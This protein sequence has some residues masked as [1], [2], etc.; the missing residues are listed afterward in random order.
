MQRMAVGDQLAAGSSTVGSGPQV[1][2]NCAACE[3]EERLQKKEGEEEEGILPQVQK[4]PIFESNEKPPGGALQAKS[5]GTLSEASPDLESRLSA[6]QGSGQALPENTRGSMESAFGADFSSVRVHTGSEAVQM[7][8]ELGAQAFTHGSDVYFG[9]GKY[10]PGSTEGNRLLGHELT[11]VVQQGGTVNNSR[12]QPKFKTLRKSPGIQRWAVNNCTT[13]QEEELNDAVSRAYND[14]TIVLP[15][16][17]ERP[18]PDYVKNALWLAFREDSDSTADLVKDNIQRLKNQITGMRLACVDR[19][20][21]SV[22]GDHVA[23]VRAGLVSICRPTF[24]GDDVSIN[25]RSGNIIHEGAHQYL[26]MFDRGYFVINTCN[27]STHPAGNFD[28]GDQDSGTAGDNPSYRLENA[29]SYSC[30]VHYLRYTPRANLDNRAASYHGENLFIESEDFNF[31][32]YT[33][34]TTP[35]LRP[36]YISGLPHNSGFRFRWRIRAN[37]ETFNPS[38]IVGGIHAGAFNEEN[39]EIFVPNSLAQLLWSNGIRQ[40]TLIC[41]IELFRPHARRSA[42]SIITKEII[43]TVENREPS[44]NF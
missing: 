28:P 19:D 20:S 9:S 6:S 18:V 2:M 24:F 39:R 25:S 26:G 43:L 42:P 33:Q 22:C 36:F 21:D 41:E 8:Q 23:Y 40:V 31:V 27:E 5:D 16:I 11:H 10:S 37:G 17:S 14:L 13:A 44:V 15:I 7:N 30:F 34:V 1:Q 38:S 4:K 3:Q 29:D 32:I 35:Q 12:V